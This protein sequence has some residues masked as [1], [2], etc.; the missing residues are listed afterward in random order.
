M[1]NNLDKLMQ[2]NIICENLELSKLIEDIMPKIEQRYTDIEL[3]A[4]KNET[5]SLVV[6]KKQTLFTKVFKA[7]S[8]TLEKF[9]IMRNLKDFELNRVEDLN[10]K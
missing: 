7:I 10:N 8:I 9:R 4:N 3:D 5:F 1:E 6:Y 2:K